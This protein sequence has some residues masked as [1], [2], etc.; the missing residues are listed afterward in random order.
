M[1]ETT[2]ELLKVIEE[3][4]TTIKELSNRLECYYTCTR[5]LLERINSNPVETQL[6]GVDDNSDSY[7][8]KID[9]LLRRID[10]FETNLNHYFHFNK[11]EAL[12]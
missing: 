12:R 6:S 5:F 2:S 11:H 1:G 10:L 9:K 8:N 4:D 7:E 3:T